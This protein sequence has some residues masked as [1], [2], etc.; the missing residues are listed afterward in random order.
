[1]APV[2]PSQAERQQG[3][4]KQTVDEAFDRQAVEKL[5]RRPEVQVAADQRPHQRL[6]A[7][8]GQQPQGRQ[9]PFQRGVQAPPPDLASGAIQVTHRI[10]SQP[11]KEETGHAAGKVAGRIVL[12]V[13]EQQADHDDSHQAE[14]PVE[15]RI[16]DEK[17]DRIKEYL[18]RDRP[19]RPVECHLGVRH[20]LLNHEQVEQKV[21]G[22]VVHIDKGR[23]VK[24]V[25]Q[26]LPQGGSDKRHKIERIKPRQPRHGK[27]AQ[28]HPAFGNGVGI[29]PEKDVA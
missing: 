22:S 20:P 21:A 7:D 15:S 16:G 5:D 10:E 17:E 26:S 14:R 29:E 25:E 11:P 13:A 3:Q 18:D 19:R 4:R 24:G 28:P 2:F 8:I 23:A 6:G 27:T 1:M 9:T 12:C